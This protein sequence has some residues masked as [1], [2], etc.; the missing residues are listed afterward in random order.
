MNDVL[1]AVISTTVTIGLVVG[2]A[3]LL[4]R[5]SIIKTYSLGWRLV[6]SHTLLILVEMVYSPFYIQQIQGS[7][8]GSVYYLYGFVPGV[9]LTI[10][11]GRASEY[12]F[13]WV[14]QY[15]APFPS[16]VILIIV[17]PGILGI[18]LG[19]ILWYGIGLWAR[20]RSTVTQL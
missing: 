3:R 7:H 9:I 11:T 19:G 20:W 5:I 15:L 12:V 18:I 1:F 10:F 8:Y 4:K 16:A 6:I 14:T 17:V 13:S 2:S